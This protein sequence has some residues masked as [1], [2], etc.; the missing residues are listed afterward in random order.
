MG[1]DG[2]AATALLGLDGFIVLGRRSVATKHRSGGE[3]LQGD[4]SS[5]PVTEIA[6]RSDLY[7]S[8]GNI[9]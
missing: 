9:F 2:S 5:V 4:S 7:S 3:V 1:H 8:S 6:S